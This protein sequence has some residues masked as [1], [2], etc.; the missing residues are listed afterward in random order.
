MPAAVTH[1]QKISLKTK[2]KKKNTFNLQICQR[3]D[4]FFFCFYMAQGKDFILILNYYFGETWIF[5]N[6]FFSRKMSLCY[7]TRRFN[8]SARFSGSRLMYR[9][10]SIV[11]AMWL[12]LSALQFVSLRCNNAARL[13]SAVAPYRFW[14]WLQRSQLSQLSLSLST[15]KIR[16][17]RTRKSCNQQ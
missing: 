2:R 8:L 3:P 6:E 13:N 11:R 14:L 10:M 9:N 16:K 5:W 15:P 17:T 1:K 12:L 7:V 4:L